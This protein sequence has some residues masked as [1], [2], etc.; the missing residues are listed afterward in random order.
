MALAGVGYTRSPFI[1]L[2]V[3]N[4][5]QNVKRQGYLV[6]LWHPYCAPLRIS[7]MKNPF[8]SNWVRMKHLCLAIVSSCVQCGIQTSG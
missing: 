3:G 7:G 8:H 2:C 4:V 6:P 5:G 1:P